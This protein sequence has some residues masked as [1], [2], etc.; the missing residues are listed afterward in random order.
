[1]HAG[2]TPFPHTPPHQDGLKLSDHLYNGCSYLKSLSDR[3]GCASA[4]HATA[5]GISWMLDGRKHKW[6]TRL[7]VGCNSFVKA[8]TYIDN[9]V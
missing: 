8:P 1:M 9:G 4:L 5:Q 6:S 3:E 7:R 2:T